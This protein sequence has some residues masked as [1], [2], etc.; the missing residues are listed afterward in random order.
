MSTKKI[1]LINGSPRKN[2]NTSAMLNTLHQQLDRKFKSE[3]IRL[4]D[5]QIGPCIDCRGC[6]KNDL[7]CIV[8]D[9]MQALYPKIEN[10]DV[11]IIG[12]PIYWFGPSAQTKLMLDRLRP[13]YG[14]QNLAGKK[15]V[16]FTPAGTGEKDCD[17]TIEMFKR[18]FQA[19]GIKYIGSVTAEAYDIGDLKNDHTALS[20][21]EALTA[22][23]N[24][25]EL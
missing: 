19:L 13:Q 8:D 4:Y 7:K 12:T 23:L 20:E 17:L 9:D 10:A 1:L 21:V 15:A 22:K 16:L 6:K 24:S 2:G 3:F 11:L 14:S 18:S 5:Y 25:Q